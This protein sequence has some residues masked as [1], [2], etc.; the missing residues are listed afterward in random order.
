MSP[1]TV[2]LAQHLIEHIEIDALDTDTLNFLY[3]QVLEHL[4]PPA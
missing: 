4:L 3:R 2:D 1:A